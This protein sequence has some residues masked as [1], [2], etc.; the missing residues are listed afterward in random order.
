MG[1]SDTRPSSRA[2]GSP[3]RSAVHAC[4]DSCTVKEKR[5]TMNARTTCA[6][7]IS[8][9]TNRLSPRCEKRKDGI[10]ELRADFRRQLLSRR[11]P[12]ACQAAES[13]QERAAAARA[14]AGNFVELRPEVA[15]GARAAVEGDREAVRLVSNA[16]HEQQ[17]RIVTGQGDRILAIAHVQ[18][19]LLLREADGHQIRETQ[20]LERRVRGRQLALAAVDE[21]QIREGAAFLEQLAITASN[22]LVHGCKVIRGEG[23]IPG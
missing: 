20:R 8:G 6:T 15:H 5:R 12:D 3:S 22:D 1:L 14:D 18:Q 16:L 7:L 2:V 10:G 11:A 4:A 19:L 13:D 21:D 17:R 9:K 23:S